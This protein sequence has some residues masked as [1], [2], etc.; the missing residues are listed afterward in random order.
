MKEKTLEQPITKFTLAILVGNRLVAQKLINRTKKEEE[1]HFSTTVSPKMFVGTKEESQGGEK[2][3]SQHQQQSHHCFCCW[4]FCEKGL[5]F[6]WLVG[7]VGR[8]QKKSHHQGKKREGGGGERLA[9]FSL[10]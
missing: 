4:H 10:F 8:S 5:V 2:K 7:L 3:A 1:S 6:G 9:D